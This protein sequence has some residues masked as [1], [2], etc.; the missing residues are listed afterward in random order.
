MVYTKR[1]TII[2]PEFSEPLLNQQYETEAK[3][4]KLG[5]MS[6]GDCKYCCTLEK[7]VLYPNDVVKLT[8][9]V[10]NSQCS[11]KVDNYKIKLLRRTEAFDLEKPKEGQ[12]Q[13]VIYTN[14]C[15]IFSQAFEAKCPP[16][17]IEQRVFEFHIPQRIFV[18][19]QEEAR[20]KVPLIE[21]PLAQGPSSSISGKLYKVS[22]VLQFRI[23]HGVMT[24]TKDRSMPDAQIPVMIMTPNKKCIQ[25]E[26]LKSLQHPCW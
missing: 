11:K 23:K 17:E 1:V 12:K 13:K 19:E 4:K 20:M 24:A 16:K 8:L 7:D 21:K 10:D 22:Y 6:Q 25:I 9:D 18:S 14:D 15:V 2:T 26:K 3:I 5:L